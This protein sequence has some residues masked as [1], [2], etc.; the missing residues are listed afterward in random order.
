MSK[1]RIA[2]A[3][4]AGDSSPLLGWDPYQVWLT[5]VQ[6]PREQKA[7]RR[8]RPKVVEPTSTTDLSETARLRTLTALQR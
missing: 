4:D 6:Q 7:R 1:R 8:S 5:R 2:D 3:P